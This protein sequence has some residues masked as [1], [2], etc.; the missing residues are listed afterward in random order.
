MSKQ[1]IER[2]NVAQVEPPPVESSAEDGPA[3]LRWRNVAERIARD[4]QAGLYAPG[5][6]LKQ[7]D[8]ERRYDCNR[9]D[10]RRALDELVARRL[11]QHVPNR[12]HHV[13]ELQP[14]QIGHLVQLRAI[15][16]GAVA[17]LIYDRADAA[18][19]ARLDALAARFED[20]VAHGTPLAQNAANLA[21]HA[22]LVD[23]CPNP[24][25]A[26]AVRDVRSRLPSALV[27]QWPTRGWI[28][29]SIRDHAAMLQALR[30]RHKEHLRAAMVGHLRQDQRFADGAIPHC[31]A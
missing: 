21:F 2:W 8:L 15:L 25:L 28:E 23:L 1:H 22:A 4:V 14:E 27:Y 3:G 5:M 9:A 26:Q 31:A 19:L 16:E 7:I 11:V 18:S 24:E 10:I 29:Q 30:D 17:D 6:W 13:F 12:G 20:A